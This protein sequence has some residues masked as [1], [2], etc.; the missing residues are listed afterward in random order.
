VDV[1][2]VSD[3]DAEVVSDVVGVADSVVAK[4]ACS[5]KGYLSHV[6]VLS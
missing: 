1:E 5:A 2:V 4:W 3:V 6:S